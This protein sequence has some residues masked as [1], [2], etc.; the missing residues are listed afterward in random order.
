M[1]FQQIGKCIDEVLEEVDGYLV[2]LDSESSRPFLDILIR[3]L[4]Q[5]LQELQDLEEEEI[6]EA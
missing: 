4:D 3:A 6:D 1:R 2:S 5:R